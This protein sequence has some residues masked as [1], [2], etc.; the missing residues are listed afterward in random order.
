VRDGEGANQPFLPSLF[1]I[2]VE[3]GEKGAG[4]HLTGGEK[5]TNP[6]IFFLSSYSPAASEGP[7]I[8]TEW[9]DEEKG[10]E[11]RFPLLSAGRRGKEEKEKSKRPCLWRGGR[12]E[13]GKEGSLFLLAVAK[14]RS[15]VRDKGFGGG[16]KKK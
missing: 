7:G 16:R 11:R 12:K 9:V 10:K 15:R 3:K 1:R 2:L 13:K 8:G 5:K 14:R 6:H 4:P